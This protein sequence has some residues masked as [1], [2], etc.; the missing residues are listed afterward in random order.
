[1]A[2]L[3]ELINETLNKETPGIIIP[4]GAEGSVADIGTLQA[5]QLPKLKIWFITEQTTLS[6]QITSNPTEKGRTQN[7]NIILEPQS[8]NIRAKVTD[9]MGQLSTSDSASLVGAFAASLAPGAGQ[10]FNRAGSGVSN[11]VYKYLL[12]LRET[13]QPFSI[14][15]SFGRV[16]DIFFENITFDRN[17]DT[18]NSLPIQMAIKELF[19]PQ[20]ITAEAIGTIQP[21]QG[22]TSIAQQ[23]QSLGQQAGVTP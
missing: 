6:A 22:F 23:S 21:A 19:I 14:I 15:T 5:G 2:T 1:M 18:A 8:W 13:R 7:D 10:F 17:K 12:D 4:A 16:D 20:S 9:V 11:S 3:S